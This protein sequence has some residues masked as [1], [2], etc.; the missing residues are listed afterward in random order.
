ME[1]SDILLYFAV[2]QKKMRKTNIYTVLVCKLR[3]D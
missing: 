1:D 3:S 2:D